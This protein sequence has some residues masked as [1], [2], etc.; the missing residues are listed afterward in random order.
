MSTYQVD[1]I[2]LTDFIDNSDSTKKLHLSLS[3][4]PS[5]TTL[6]LSVPNTSTT[7]LG[8]DTIQTLTNKTIDATTNTIS[9]IDNTQLIAG[10][11]ASKIANGTVSDTEFQQL[12]GLTSSAVGTS[13]IQ[14]LTNKTITDATN[15]VSASQLKTTTT[16]V[17]ISTASAPTTGQVLTAINSTT[18]TWQSPSFF[19]M[20]LNN[21]GT[22]SN[23]TTLKQWNGRST[24][25]GGIANFNVT[26]DGTYTGTAIFNGLSLTTHFM[27][28]TAAFDT[29]SSTVAPFASIKSVTNSNR[30]VS[31]NVKTGNSGAIV[32]NGTY[33]GLQNAADGINVY[34]TIVGI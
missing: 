2:R 15:V 18:A 11:S 10:V 29:T 26:H 32:V 30:T 12:N 31:V 14:T 25:S 4:L 17:T 33:T 6:I 24:T 3:N 9:N 19:T 8:T 34:L 22:V 1:N 20:F 28:T 21:N 23:P 27:Q 13:D 16:S 7:I 5:D